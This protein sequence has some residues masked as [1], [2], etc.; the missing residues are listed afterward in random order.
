MKNIEADG[1]RRIRC[2]FKSSNQDL[3]SFLQII[4]HNYTCEQN[5][6]QKAFI[7][8]TQ[9][10]MRFKAAPQCTHTHRMDKKVCTVCT[11][12]N[13]SRKVYMYLKN[14]IAHNMNI[15]IY[16]Y[17]YKRERLGKEH[18]FLRSGFGILVMVW[19]SRKYK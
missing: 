6:E 13:M 7:V 19:L 5:R 1:M 3:R 2:I 8:I 10:V 9:S 16:R 14:T 15:Y 11:M 17:I 12:S 18:F 4:T